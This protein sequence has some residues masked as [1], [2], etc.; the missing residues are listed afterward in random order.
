MNFDESSGNEDNVEEEQT[1]SLSPHADSTRP[2]S[3]SSGK[4]VAVRSPSNQLPK[5]PH[6]C[7]LYLIQKCTFTVCYTPQEVIT[8]GSP[9]QD[10]SL[11]DVTN[12]EE[13]VLRPAPRGITIKCRISRDKKGMDRG[14]YPTYFMHMERED[15]KKV[16]LTE[17]QT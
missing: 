9:T 15:G 5:K 2:A 6:S 14:L 8:P 1:R 3:A 12:L 11:I 7:A 13:F 17:T 16:S 4:D 10:S